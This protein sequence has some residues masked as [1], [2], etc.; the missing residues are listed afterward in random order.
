MGPDK[1]IYGVFWLLLT[2]G[3]IWGIC[4]MINMKRGKLEGNGFNMTR[5]FLATGFAIAAGT[6]S[7]VGGMNLLQDQYMV[8]EIADFSIIVV[9]VGAT[10]SVISMLFILRIIF[11]NP[12]KGK[13][14]LFAGKCF[15]GRDGAAD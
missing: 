2:I 8:G 7:V 4:F 3:L 9:A 12:L 5:I 1:M 14:A 13:W 6:G 15:A 10:I 11:G